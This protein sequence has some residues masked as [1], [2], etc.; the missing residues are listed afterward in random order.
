MIYVYAVAWNVW[1]ACL[2]VIAAACRAIVYGL[3]CQQYRHAGR[4]GLASD[5]IICYN[6]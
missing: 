6:V 1:Q 5:D 4:K 3:P 2:V